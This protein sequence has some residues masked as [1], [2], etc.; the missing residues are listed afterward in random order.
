MIWVSIVGTA[1]GIFILS[2]VTK[3]YH[4]NNYG[5]EAVGNRSVSFGKILKVA[6]IAGF[7]FTGIFILMILC[8]YRNIQ[9]SVGVLR[10]SAIIIMRNF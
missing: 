9:V 4:N 5:P 3:E 7:V 10:T 8:M 1:A 6:Y 2:I